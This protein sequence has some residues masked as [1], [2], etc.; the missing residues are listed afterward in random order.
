M[1]S[2]ASREK[3]LNDY[4]R[5]QDSPNRRPADAASLI[6]VRSVSGEDQVLMGRRDTR[7]AFM[8]DVYV[9]PGGRVDPADSRL[10]VSNSLNAGVEAK[11]LAGMRGRPSATRARA[12]GLA[13]IRET[14]EEAGLIVGRP[15]EAQPRTRSQA[16][17]NFLA[18]GSEPDLSALRFVARAI[19]PPRRP[20][21]FDTRFFCLRVS[22]P[23]PSAE[24]RDD[25]LLELRWLPLA[26][27]G[28]IEVAPITR[29]VLEELKDRLQGDR[30]APDAPVPFYRWISDGFRREVI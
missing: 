11:L 23:L 12:L 25:E 16:W 15:A 6:L 18:Q 24:G 17:S 21:R 5:R 22:E 14:F 26:D 1:R 2:V 30:L 19:T 13:A 27:P 7:H 10:A 9:F 3:F 8:P 28:D 4:P 20:R 29:V